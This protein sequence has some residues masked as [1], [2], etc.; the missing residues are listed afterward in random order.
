MIFLYIKAYISFLELHIKLDIFFKNVQ[1]KFEFLLSRMIESSD[2]IIT[3][4]IPEK[5]K[6]KKKLLGRISESEFSVGSES[7]SESLS[8]FG[9]L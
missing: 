5:K 4:L 8:G 2:Y 9:F 7:E 3:Y 1:I 6:L